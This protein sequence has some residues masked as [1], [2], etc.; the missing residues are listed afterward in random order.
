MNCSGA[1]GRYHKPNKNT[2]HKTQKQPPPPPTPPPNTKKT[3]KTGLRT[4]FPNCTSLIYGS[5]LSP[6]SFAGTLIF[7]AIHPTLQ[8]SATKRG[9]AFSHEYSPRY[10]PPSP[11]YYP[12][13]PLSTSTYP[14]QPPISR[15]ISKPPYTRNPP[16]RSVLPSLV[17]FMPFCLRHTEGNFDPPSH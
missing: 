17:L 4:A 14:P 12:R 6:L 5:F 13:S 16:R 3:C 15:T 7:K 11:R 8:I 1:R 10:L 9:S 2:P